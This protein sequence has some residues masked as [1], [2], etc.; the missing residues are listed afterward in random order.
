MRAQVELRAL[1][2]YTGAIDGIMGP[3]TRSA[4]VQFQRSRRLSETGTLDN[5]TLAAMGLRC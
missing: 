2:L 4:L 5:A 1:G 3:G